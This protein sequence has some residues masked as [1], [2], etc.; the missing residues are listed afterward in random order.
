MAAFSHPG[1]SRTVG[2]TTTTF[3]WDI[4]ASLS[5]VLHDGPSGEE[6]LCG[7]GLSAMKQSGDWSC[8]LASGLGST[9][10]AVDSTGMVVRDYQYDVYG[11]PTGG[12]GSLANEFDFAGQQTDP[13]G[14]Q[15]LRARYYDPAAGVFL[16]REPLE[17][18]PGWMGNLFG[19]AGGNPAR[20]VDPTGLV[21]VDGGQGGGSSKGTGGRGGG[22]GTSGGNRVTGKAP[23]GWEPIL[24]G[25]AGVRS[26]KG[27]LES[28]GH[29]IVGQEVRVETPWGTRVIDL[30]AEYKGKFYGIEVKNGPYA[31]QR[32]WQQIKDGWLNHSPVEVTLA[33][34]R[35]VTLEGTSTVYVDVP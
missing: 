14:L 11:A 4:N 29:R 27:A 34:G 26:I 15:Y 24:K 13:T 7:A 33:D 32:P 21:P 8:Y 23:G 17:R 16:S 25:R 30:I 22:G 6:Y 20:L 18:L 9:M 12:S 28:E 2:M 5:V 1:H 35:V 10:A 31:R 19:Y 3:T